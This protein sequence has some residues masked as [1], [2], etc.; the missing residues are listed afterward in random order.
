ADATRGRLRQPGRRQS[1]P[2]QPH[3]PADAGGIRATG[4]RTAGGAGSAAAVAVLDAVDQAD[5]G[6]ARLRRPG[7]LHPHHHPA[8]GRVTECFPAA[9][10]GALSSAGYQ[11][12][13]VRNF[14]ATSR[15]ACIRLIVAGAG[16]VSVRVVKP[17]G[18]RV[19]LVS[20]G[21]SDNCP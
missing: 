18:P 20:T 7:L 13:P 10:A 11:S 9:V 19:S 17:T 16:E 3:L 1:Y 4:D 15:T 14:S 21:S 6:R 2:P 5:R 12:F 8:A